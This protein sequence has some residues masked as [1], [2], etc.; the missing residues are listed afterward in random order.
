M[1]SVNRRKRSVLADAEDN[2]DLPFR[3]ARLDA[4]FSGIEF[5]LGAGFVDSLIDSPCDFQRINETERFFKN[6]Q[7]PVFRQLEH[8]A[9]SFFKFPL[10]ETT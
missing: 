4:P 5:T 10:D 1:L 7:R 3:L 8:F 9:Q 2:K 6:S